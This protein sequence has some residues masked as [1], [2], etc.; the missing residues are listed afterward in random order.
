MAY[1][2]ITANGQSFALV[3]QKDW[4][5][6]KIMP[7]S[8]HPANQV[9]QH[10]INDAMLTQSDYDDFKKT[11]R[12]MAQGMAYPSPVAKAIWNG[13][14]PT[15]AFR[16]HAGLTQDQLAAKTGFTKQ[17][18]SNLETGRQNLSRGAMQKIAAALNIPQALLLDD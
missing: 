15:K 9:K 14:T 3:P 12:A 2:I 7:L 6:L 11:K 10:Q 8:V 1:D 5:R 17:Y 18:I 16:R 13:A 4:Q